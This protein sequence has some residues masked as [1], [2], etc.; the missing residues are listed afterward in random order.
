[1]EDKEIENALRGIYKELSYLS[2]Q[3]TYMVKLLERGVNKNE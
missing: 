2:T 1:M 3:V